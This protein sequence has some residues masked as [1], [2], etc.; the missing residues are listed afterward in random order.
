MSV[1]IPDI[2]F[3]VAAHSNTIGQFTGLFDEKRT[4]IFEGNIIKDSL[5]TAVVK[6]DAGSF[7]ASYIDISHLAFLCCSPVCKVIGNIYYNPE[8]I[9]NSN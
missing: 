7:L 9:N 8:L 4:K 1:I 5:G 6:F 2:G 3:T